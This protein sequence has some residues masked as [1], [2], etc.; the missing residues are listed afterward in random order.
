MS[1]LPPPPPATRA[2]LDD[3]ALDWFLRRR[4]GL[5]PAEAAALQAW[6]AATPAHGEALDGWER[7]WAELDGLPAAGVARLR[8]QLAAEL[9]A[10]TP[11]RRRI[12][13]PARAARAARATWAPAGVAALVL[14][15]SGIGYRLWGAHPQEPPLFTQSFATTRGQQLALTLPD[16][17]HLRLDTA[18]RGEVALYPQRREVR[19]PEGQ[20]MFE[21]A[22]DAARPFDVWAGPLR[23]TVLGTRFAV[24]YTPSEAG[25]GRVHVEVEEGRVRVADAQQQAGAVAVEL[26]AGQQVD[27][28]AQ[29]HL[30]AVSALPADAIAGW[31]EGR[32]SFEN[33]PLAQVLAEFARYGETGLVLQDRRVAALRLTG[34]F[35]ARHLENFRRVLPQVLPVRLQTRGDLTEI[36][37]TP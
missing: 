29:G 34:T 26:G 27:S 33:A 5:R 21:V 28:D 31:R 11:P 32:L 37:A 2:D 24:R 19:L 22:R 13:W 3:Q 7:Q 6:L 1:L 8:R 23:I 4:A 10:T 9:A 17:S 12:G 16:G 36:Q 30:G 25:D 15:L 14:V 20:A 18:T 35:D